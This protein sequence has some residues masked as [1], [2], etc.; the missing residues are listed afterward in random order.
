MI[1][2]EDVIVSDIRCGSEVDIIIIIII[3]ITKKEWAGGRE[4]VIE[5]LELLLLLRRG[6]YTC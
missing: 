3:I 4:C 6:G 5:G 1:Q 2:K